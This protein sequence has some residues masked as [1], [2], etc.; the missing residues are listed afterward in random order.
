MAEDLLAKAKFILREKDMPMFSDEEIQAYIDSSE[1]FDMALFELLIL[2]SENTGL[3]LSGV[4]IQDTSDYF[5]KLAWTYRP[6]N[7]GIL[8]G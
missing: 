5:R 7:S 8:G 4:E 3:V 1:S 2:K 6:N